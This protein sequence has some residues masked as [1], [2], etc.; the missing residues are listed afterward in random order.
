MKAVEEFLQ[1]SP[2]GK[3]WSKSDNQNQIKISVTIFTRSSIGS[4]LLG[5]TL[6]KEVQWTSNHIISALKKGKIKCWKNSVK[7]HNAS[8]KY[9][10]QKGKCV[11]NNKIKIVFNWKFHILNEIYGQQMH[12]VHQNLYFILYNK[13][14][15]EI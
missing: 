6:R 1:T 10:F 7:F 3:I 4:K 9:F 11:V 8:Y 2:P 13:I 14:F 12:F 15:S 5:A